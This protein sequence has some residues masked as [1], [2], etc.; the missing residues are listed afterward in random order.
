MH[1]ILR[2]NHSLS[3]LQL[4][5]PIAIQ[6]T[7]KIFGELKTTLI[8]NLQ[9]RFRG[10]PPAFRSA[11]RLRQCSGENWT[12]FGKNVTA[13][14]A[15]SVW[16]FS[17][18]IQ[19][20]IP[21]S[22][23]FETDIHSASSISNKAT[24]KLQPQAEQCVQ[25][26]YSFRASRRRNNRPRLQNWLQ[27]SKNAAAFFLNALKGTDNTFVTTAIQ[28]LLKP[29]MEPLLQVAFLAAAA[30]LL[31]DRPTAHFALKMPILFHSKTTCNI[32][33]DSQLA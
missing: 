17:R 5:T 7:K 31:Y 21:Y 19:F 30:R 25:Q 23:W 11:A 22:V 10:Q 6:S 15:L 3:F 28:R 9:N 8:I 16:T 14:T 20:F 12:L 33:A 1:P 4:F 13:Q 24:L 2:F 29:Q 32:N 27:A 18:K 26:S